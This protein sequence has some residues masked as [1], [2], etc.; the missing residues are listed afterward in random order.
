[1][2]QHQQVGETI[3][4]L[5]DTQGKKQCQSRAVNMLGKEPLRAVP[6]NDALP[7]G[8]RESNVRA[9]SNPQR[10]PDKALTITPQEGQNPTPTFCRFCGKKFSDLAKYK[11]HEAYHSKVGRFPC[12]YCG[13]AFHNKANLERHERVHTGEKPF[14]CLY[15]DKRFREATRRTSHQL[16]HE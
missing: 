10:L 11:A 13:K 16:T 9:T 5:N 14:K 15:C 7:S 2:P 6:F 1:M 12:N 3:S 4:I 8:K